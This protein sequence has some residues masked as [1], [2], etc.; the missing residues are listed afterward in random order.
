MGAKYFFYL[1]GRNIKGSFIN[2]LKFAKEVASQTEIGFLI[3]IASLAVVPIT[4][5]LGGGIK[6]LIDFFTR[7]RMSATRMTESQNSIAAMD[8]ATMD[9]LTQHIANNYTPR[10]Q[11]NSSRMLLEQLEAIQYE[12]E[13][14]V[15][16]L[17]TLKNNRARE[18]LGPNAHIY[19]EEYISTLVLDETHQALFDQD[20]VDARLNYVEQKLA[21]KKELFEGYM[22]QNKNLGKRL[23]ATISRFHPAPENL[24]AQNNEPHVVV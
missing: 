3:A 14:D 20:V 10:S 21:R 13:D 11:S 9:N 8:Q 4:M 24:L 17:S 6:T 7:K 12:N 22:G 23:F 15:I 16:G 18:Q 2:T 19:S 1:Y 5:I